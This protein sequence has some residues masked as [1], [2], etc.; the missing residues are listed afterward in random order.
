[1]VKEEEKGEEK[2]E[3]D[4]SEKEEKEGEKGEG[5]FLET[6]EINSARARGIDGRNW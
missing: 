5:K 6:L 2:K 4:R 3:N 1:M